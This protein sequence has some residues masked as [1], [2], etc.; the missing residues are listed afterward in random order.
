MNDSDSQQGIAFNYLSMRYSQYRVGIRGRPCLFLAPREA[1]RSRVGIHYNHEAFTIRVHAN[2][3]FQ[4]PRARSPFTGEG[5]LLSV[6]KKVLR[7]TWLE[8]PWI[9]TR[10]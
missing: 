4:Q 5:R 1:S 10:G 3:Q 8:K 7:V 9:S 6:S 2:A